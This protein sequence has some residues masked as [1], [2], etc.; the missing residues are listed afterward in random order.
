MTVLLTTR[1]ADLRDLLPSGRDRPGWH[2]ALSHEIV[3]RLSPAHAAILARP[4]PDPEGTAW[5]ADG[6][7]AVPL[8]ALAL[9]ERRA[10]LA[11]AGSI[12][13]DIRRLAESGRSPLVA[14]CWP[15]LREIPD[16]GYL[17]AVDGRPVLAAWGY[18][19][20][21]AAVTPGLLAPYDDGL[22]WVMPPPRRLP[23]VTL[24]A[25][26]AVGLLLGLALAAA[27]GAFPPDVCQ[28]QPGVRAALAAGLRAHAQQAALETRL[29]ALRAAVLT[30]RQHCLAAAKSPPPVMH[31]ALPPS[32]LPLAIQA[33]PSPAAVPLPPAPPPAL[34]IQAW[35][36]HDL[37]M[38]NGCWH[39]YTNMVTR[40]PYT[41]EVNR[42]ASWLLCFNNSGQG[43]QKLVWRDGVSCTNPITAHFDPGGNLTIQDT[44]PCGQSA[45]TPRGLFLG[46]E[47]CSRVSPSVASCPR[48]WLAGPNPGSISPGMF[49]R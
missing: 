15:A 29:Q 36:Q 28:L 40:N 10:L 12:L 16:F 6:A 44:I 31:A 7:H 45:S 23:P 26:A 34:P 35:R 8:G 9:P 46:R 20:A 17:F 43:V 27:N 1:P 14:S 18:A 25:L 47:N 41:G 37:G 32:A 30:G 4:E 21:D 49:R 13:S 19:P 2:A 42:V 33:P 48:T 38:L 39:R 5:H 22:G 24:G 11:A 3:A